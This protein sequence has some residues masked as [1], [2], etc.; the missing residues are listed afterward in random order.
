MNRRHRPAPRACCGST[1]PRCCI[2]LNCEPSTDCA[3]VAPRQTTTTGLIGADLRLEP[4]PACLDFRHSRLLVNAPLAARLPLE[5]L[6]RVRHVHIAARNAGLL[7]CLVQQCAG[8][9]D[10]GRSLPI[11]LV[12]RLLADEHDVRGARARAEH[13]LRRR[14]YS[15]QPRHSC[16]AAFNVRRLVVF[17]TNGA[18]DRSEH[19]GVRATSARFSAGLDVIF[20]RHQVNRACRICS[21]PGG[22]SSGYDRGAWKNSG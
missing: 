20:L 13:N 19:S 3:A 14:S 4:R 2:N 1:C 22:M 5:V 12:T 7:E 9:A 15:S 17:G 16:A 10:K 21:S 8:G 6:D 11:F 18:A